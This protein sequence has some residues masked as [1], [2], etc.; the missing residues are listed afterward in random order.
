MQRHRY[1]EKHKKWITDHLHMSVI[2]EYNVFITKFNTGH[3]L[4][5]F[6]TYRAKINNK[7]KRHRRFTKEEDSWIIANYPHKGIEV[8]Y[9]EFIKVFGNVHTRESYISRAKDLGVKVTDARW[10]QACK[11]NG[12]RDNVPI[13]TIQKRGRGHNW[14]K[15]GDGTEGWIPLTQYLL[16][17]NKDKVIIHL[18]GNKTNDSLDN[19]RVVSRQVLA[20]MSK[21]RFWSENS[22][23]TET[24]ILCCELQQLLSEEEEVIK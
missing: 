2:D 23:I 13:G 18:D 4:S 16:G 15:I 20:R 11:N 5:S 7:G 3:T 12:Y 21:Q 14:I 24:G 9:P 10:R 22:V 17:N 19:L 1:S 8:G 6:K